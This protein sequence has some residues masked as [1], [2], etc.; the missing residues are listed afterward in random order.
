MA[1]LPNN[2]R[3]YQKTLEKTRSAA[4]NFLDFDLFPFGSGPKAVKRSTNLSHESI[5]INLYTYMLK[6]SSLHY[7]KILSIVRYNPI[8][9]ILLS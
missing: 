3:R 5:F 2:S 4:E 9:V 8:S 6:I 1:D 7:F